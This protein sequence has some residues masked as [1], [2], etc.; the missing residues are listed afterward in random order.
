MD[1]SSFVFLMG[2]DGKYLAHFGPG[3]TPE[4]MADAIR[5]RL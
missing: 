3:T 5:P 1:H 2:R 4:Q